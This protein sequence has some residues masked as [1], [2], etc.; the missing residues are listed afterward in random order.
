MSVVSRI[1]A[2][3]LANLRASPAKSGVLLVGT[4]VLIVLVARGIGGKAKPAEATVTAEQLILKPATEG[5]TP[6]AAELRDTTNVPVPRMAQT[7]RRNPFSTAWMGLTEVPAD[8]TNGE[9]EEEELVLQFTMMSEGDSE[10]TAVISGV[11]VYPG[12]V[13]SG[14]KV[15]AIGSRF[16][17]LKRNSEEVVLRMP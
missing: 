7:L 8:G 12:S 16:V 9:S 4:V 6:V 1:K 15:V 14:Y 10:A 5:T 11:V 3:I 17:V 2:I 13:V